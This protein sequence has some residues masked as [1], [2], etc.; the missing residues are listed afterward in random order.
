MAF[1]AVTPDGAYAAVPALTWL[2]QRTNVMPRSMAACGVWS[3]CR[4]QVAPDVNNNRA[5]AARVR[6]SR[7]QSTVRF[8]ERRSALHGKASS[9]LARADQ[10][11]AAAPLSLKTRL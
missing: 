4:G 3:G 2:H 1:A 6:R 8:S 7:A 11:S 10:R 9:S 5:F